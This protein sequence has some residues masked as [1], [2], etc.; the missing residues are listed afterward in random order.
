MKITAYPESLCPG[1]KA[2]LT[3]SE[4]ASD[5]KNCSWTITSH[6]CKSFTYPNLLNPL[7]IQ[8]QA[9]PDDPNG[10]TISV[11][12]V[13]GKDSAT[14]VFTVHGI[15]I[16]GTASVSNGQDMDP[17]VTWF[18]A[19][20]DCLCFGANRRAGKGLKVIGTAKFQLAGNC[21]RKAECAQ[22]FE[23]GFLQNA[24]HQ[25]R[26]AEYEHGLWVTKAKGEFTNGSAPNL[27]LGLR[28]AEKEESAFCFGND[29]CKRFTGNDDEQTVE[30]FDNPGMY[31]DIKLGGL[32]KLTAARMDIRFQTWLAVRNVAWYAL[33]RDASMYFI[34]NFLWGARGD[35]RWDGQE[36][37]KIRSEIKVKRVEP[38]KGSGDPILSG[39]VANNLT[40]EKK[41]VTK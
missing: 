33:E 11:K 6:S 12:A 37:G 19:D 22:N 31:R 13:A 34:C 4:F 27:P 40:T 24:I 28:D 3:A 17:G 26:V 10:G 2:T 23:L 32:G 39:P 36:V 1:Q 7:S 15:H 20:H 41:S 29:K 9:L 21:A 5:P 25:V 35:W 8:V 30:F 38:G 18:D 14:Q 16:T